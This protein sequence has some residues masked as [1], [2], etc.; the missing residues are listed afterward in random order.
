MIVLVFWKELPIF[1]LSR[2]LVD[3][4]MVSGAIVWQNF[5]LDQIIGPFNSLLAVI[6]VLYNGFMILLCS[7]GSLGKYPSY[8]G[9]SNVTVNGA[10]FTGT[11]NGVRIKTWQGGKGFANGLTFE[12]IHMNNVQNPIV[13]DQFYC[14]HCSASQVLGSIPIFYGNSFLPR[15][16]RFLHGTWMSCN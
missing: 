7:V 16:H 4:V 13:I 6:Y 3:L 5:Q 9:V 15:N 10:S 11:Q 14:P 2:L 12:N 1:T 8:K